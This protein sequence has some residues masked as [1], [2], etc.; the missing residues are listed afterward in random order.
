LRVYVFTGL[1]VGWRV[2]EVKSYELRVMGYGKVG[3]AWWRAVREFDMALYGLG[4]E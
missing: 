4:G 1:R 3:R 2:G